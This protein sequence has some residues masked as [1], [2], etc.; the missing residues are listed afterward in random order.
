MKLNFIYCGMISGIDK[1]S[2]VKVCLQNFCFFYIFVALNSTK[3][4][5]VPPPGA[6]PHVPNSL[7]FRVSLFYDS[8]LALSV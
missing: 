4:T 7:G 3:I 6:A 2:L 1:C 8:S 5:T